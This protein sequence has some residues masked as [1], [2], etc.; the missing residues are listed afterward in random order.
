M[1]WFPTKRT[2]AIGLIYTIHMFTNEMFTI[3]RALDNI[4]E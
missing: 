3:Q 1:K 2:A 4:V